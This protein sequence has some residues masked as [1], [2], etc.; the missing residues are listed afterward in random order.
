MAEI[1]CAYCK[2]TPKTGYLRVT[3]YKPDGTADGSVD[4]CALI[5]LMSW[6]YA[7]SAQRIKF[8]VTLGKSAFG[9]LISSIRGG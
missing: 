5:C 2:R 7:Y 6:S 4:V 1:V 8:G 9:Q 3:R